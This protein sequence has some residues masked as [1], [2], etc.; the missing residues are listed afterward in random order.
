MAF[1]SRAHICHCLS[2]L[3]TLR[4]HS[5]VTISG[6]RRNTGH[7]FVDG[8]LSLAQGLLDLGIRSGDVVAISALNS[9]RYLEC[10]LAVAFVGGVVAPLNYR[11][12]F[13]E[14]RFAME[15][16]KPVMLITDSSCSYWYPKL[17]NDHLPS[18][19]W[20]VFMDSLSEFSSKESTLTTEML[21]KPALKSLS[22]NYAWAP[23]GAVLICFTSGTTGRPKGVTI[24][25]SALIIQ[26]LAKIAIVGYDEDD[27]YLHTAPLCHIGGLSSA[28]T[29]LMVGGCHI[30]I[31]KFDAKLALEAIKQHHVTSLITVPAIMVDLVSIIRMKM[32]WKV[33]ES[34][35]KILNGGG[36]LSN[37][38]IEDAI[39]FFPRAKIL[40]AYGMTET[41]SSL[42]FMTLYD[43]TC[44][45]S[46]QALQE[47]VEI[48][49]SS[50]HLPEGVCV[51]KPAPH[52]ELKICFDSSDH[53]GRILTRGPHIMLRYWDQISSRP[54]DS[55]DEGWLDTGDIGSIDDYGN[56]WL[57]GRTNNRIK[58]GGENVYPE[59]VETVLSQHPG[60]TGSVVVG[61]PDVRLTEMVV[62]CI[63]IKD[64]WQ[65]ADNSPVH[66]TEKKE[67]VLSSETLRHHC[68]EKNLT[69]FKIPKLFTLWRKPF[70]LT[71]TGKLRRYQVQREVLS[72]LHS[73][74][75]NL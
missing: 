38:L 51:G 22:F 32:T 33:T 50:F 12:S 37:G 29:M 7:Q 47:F 13:E 62:A 65:W 66:P 26:S 17:E 72:H 3:A 52:V 20:H 70:P 46:R 41:C 64:N 45:S 49:S 39:K 42:T 40:S 24:S 25:H 14:A 48:K 35:K 27:V 61:L 69:G 54:S 11:W 57:I 73:L 9:D 74:P 68:R 8:V 1:Y 53:V 63:R 67:L 16:V 23:E 19:R 10:F 58:S 28:L 71:S 59:E 60:V 21:K 18:L 6:N 43:P 30:F 55:P 36:G 4:I 2:R 5:A 75:S 31:P 34:V 56:I 15:M 44:A